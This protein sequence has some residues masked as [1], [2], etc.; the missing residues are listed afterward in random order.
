VN[1]AELADALSSSLERRADR[2][3]ARPDA[4]HLLARFERRVAVQ[5][6]LLLGALVVVLAV[7]AGAGYLAGSSGTRTDRAAIVALDDGAPGA[8]PTGSPIEPEDV[9][10]AVAAIDQAFHAVFDGGVPDDVRRS[11]TQGGAVLDGLRRETLAIAESRGYTADDLAGISID[12]YGTTFVD[13]T[14]G[15]VHFTLSVPGHGVVLK[16]QIGYAIFE[17]GRWRVSLRTSCDLLSLSGL[18]RECPPPSAFT[19]ARGSRS[20][21]G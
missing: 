20:Q 9:D 5:R 11:A 8:Q 1:D 13:R 10:A 15:V 16:D 18:G 14:H 7:G 3:Q 21:Q 19:G 12:V 6:R 17:A 2:V 4:A